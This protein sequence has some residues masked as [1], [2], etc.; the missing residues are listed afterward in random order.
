MNLNLNSL[1]S[2][3]MPDSLKFRLHIWL[4]KTS[5]YVAIGTKGSLVAK[6]FDQ[7]KGIPGWFTLDDCEHFHLV[8]EMQSLNGVRGDMLEIG[9]YHGRST[10]IMAGGIRDGE[11]IHVCDAFESGTSDG[12]ANKPS[13]EKLLSNIQ[14]AN[15]G[16]DVTQVKIHKCLSNDL[17]FPEDQK[18]RFIHIDGGHSAKEVYADLELAKR[19]LEPLGIIVIDDYG[20]KHWPTVTT[21]VDTFMT[22]NP[23]CS[24]LGDLNRHGA[25]GRKLYVYMAATIADEQ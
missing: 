25:L 14:N 12:Y 18:F 19:H 24:V 2:R 11:C 9:S 6:G 22:D 15:P 1:A 4:K 5:S 10:A 20:H 8:M 7:V 3:L 17:N 16:F 23:Q 13:P 21:G